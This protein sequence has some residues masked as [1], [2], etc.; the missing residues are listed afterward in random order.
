MTSMRVKYILQSSAFVIAFL[1]SLAVFA[2]D[3]QPNDPKGYNKVDSMLLRAASKGKITYWLF[4]NIYEEPSPSN[5]EINK[6]PNVSPDNYKRYQGK[7]IRNIE[8]KSLDPFGTQIQDTLL[9]NA[10]YL[11]KAGNKIHVSTTKRTVKSQLLFDK[12]DELDPLQLRESERLLRRQEYIRDARIVIV[13]L[14]NKSK[15][16]VDVLVIVQDR[17]SLNGSLGMSTTQS[18]FN[19]TETNFL[20]TGSRITQ[21]G[22]Y[23]FNR[24]KFTDWSGEFKD[25]NI[26]NTYIDGAIFYNTTPFLRSRGIYFDRTF[27]SPLTKWAGATG[28]THYDRDLEYFRNDGTLIPAKLK[29]NISEL[30]VGRSFPLSNHSEAD[31]SSSVILSGRYMNNHYTDR[32]TKALDSFFVFQNQ[33]LYLFSVGF[34]TRRYYK[35]RKI[36]RFGNTEDVPEGRMFSITFGKLDEETADYLYAS[37][38][39]AAGQHVEGLGYVSGSAEY[40]TFYNNYIAQKGVFN[41]DGTYF[42]D[43]WTSGKWNMRQFIYL[44]TTNGLNRAPG[45]FITING[46]G[47]EGLYGFNSSSVA[48]RN[49]SLIKFE[50]IIYTPFNVAGFQIAAVVFAGFGKIGRNIYPTIKDQTIYQAYGVGFLIR[51]ENIVFN[52]IRIALGYYPN[53]PAGS[54]AEYRFNPFGISNLNLRDYDITRPELINYR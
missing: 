11:E 9:H 13:P 15:D 36:F 25:N 21:G 51:K 42:S 14:K 6:K 46:R 39:V 53:I 4:K 54:G 45:E 22:K 7:I 17:W 10:G 26:R 16:S 30:W 37:L 50:S 31:R 49:K 3:Q 20:G 32:P 24:N 34:S 43:L 19:I 35:D 23:D 8:I 1:F 47:N 12:G 44:R 28:Y 48:G 27:Y 29:N 40:G 5:N 18:D 33:N 38:K 41:F 52:T 2:Q